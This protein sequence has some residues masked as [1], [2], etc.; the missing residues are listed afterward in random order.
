VWR[1]TGL[2][3]SGRT[4]YTAQELQRLHDAPE[5]GPLCH[6]V[7]ASLLA[8]QRIPV[9]PKFA[10]RGLER[11]TVVDFQND[12]RAL[13]DREYVT[14][15]CLLKAAEVARELTDEEAELIGRQLLGDDAR[16]FVACVQ[17]LRERRGEPIE[18]VL[19]EALDRLWEDGLSHV[20]RTAL[21]DI[22]RR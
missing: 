18:K 15:A 10:Q 4:K 14:G 9:A 22:Q 16:F 21:Q 6:L 19:P 2:V 12:C 7:I 1:E 17:T 20:V 3:I 13:L 11:L 8:L 5:T